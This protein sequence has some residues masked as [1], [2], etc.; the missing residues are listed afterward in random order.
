METPTNALDTEGL[1]LTLEG[2][3]LLFERFIA[4]REYDQAVDLVEQGVPDSAVY[5]VLLRYGYLLTRLGIEDFVEDEAVTT[6]RSELAKAQLQVAIN[7]AKGK[8]ASSEV[9]EAAA[10]LMGK[11]THVGMTGTELEAVARFANQ[12]R[13]QKLSVEA[14]T[15]MVAMVGQGS[16]IFEAIKAILPRTT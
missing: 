5:R 4:D 11:T 3:R 6:Q 9:L 2:V 13:E 8:A 16:N 14:A 7:I 15:R 12:I 1:Q 10:L